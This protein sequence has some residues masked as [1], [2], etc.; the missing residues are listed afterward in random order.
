MASS[1]AMASLT[2]RL[3]PRLGS[4]VARLSLPAGRLL[5]FEARRSLAFL[6]LPTADRELLSQ[7]WQAATKRAAAT[8]A[9]GLPASEGMMVQV[10]FKL[11]RSDTGE[12]VDSSEGKG[13]LGFVCGGQQVLPGLDNG[14]KGMVVGETRDIKLD[15]EAGFGERDEEQTTTVP[16]EKLPKGVEVGSELE[17]QSP[18]GPMMAIVK[19]ISETTATLDFNH[20]MA[21]MPLTMKVTLVSCSEAPSEPEIVVETLKEGDGV[22]FPKKGDRLTMHYTGTLASTGVKFDSSRD[23]EAEPFAFQIGVGQVIQGWDFGV[24]KMSLG[25]RAILRVPA[26]LGYGSRGAGGVIPPDADL[27]FDVELLKIN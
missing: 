7:P 5:R 19:G 9:G 8:A 17:V 4:P 22:T 25:E 18:N 15:C 13:P 23:R 14:V 1:I 11:T 12:L 21:G 27:V 16:L 20:P 24:M 3:G 10:E 26:D 2:R 6:R